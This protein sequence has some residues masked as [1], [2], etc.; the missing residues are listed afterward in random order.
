MAKTT[1]TIGQPHASWLGM[2]FESEDF[3]TF[4]KEK[5]EREPNNIFHHENMALQTKTMVIEQLEN[6]IKDAE[7]ERIEE[8]RY[9]NRFAPK[10]QP[11]NQ[12]D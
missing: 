1:V 9:N 5:H 6:N 4:I 7:N 11:R 8:R 2:L 3:K 10:S 12:R